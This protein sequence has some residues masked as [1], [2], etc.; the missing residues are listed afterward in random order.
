[1]SDEDRRGSEHGILPHGEWPES[2][3]LLNYEDLSAHYEPMLFKDEA[4]SAPHCQQRS[5]DL[6]AAPPF[7]PLS[8]DA[9]P[10]RLIAE[11]M[12]TKVWTAT[13]ESTVEEVEHHFET[14]SGLPV[15]DKDLNV[16]GVI[17]KK[18]KASSQ[19]TTKVSEIMS[20]PAIT[21]DSNQTILE[22][23]ILML[24]NKVHRIPVTNESN[25][26]VGMVTRTDIFTA[27][28]EKA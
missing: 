10:S 2:F 24:K 16:V 22:A 27:L 12:K 1:M 25:K 4:S 5:L 13:P 21:V 6:T 20:T 9:Q 8:I 23:A 19:P 3:S 26:L 7:C 18:D 14:I 11:V 17:S 15:V 28:E